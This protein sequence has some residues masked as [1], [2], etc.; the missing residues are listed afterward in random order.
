MRSVKSL[1]DNNARKG[2]QQRLHNN[3][4]RHSDLAIT[5]IMTENRN[6]TVRRNVGAFGELGK[7]VRERRDLEAS[8]AMN[9]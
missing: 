3:P 6:N 9:F 4:L 1:V 2:R 5:P 7:I 8:D